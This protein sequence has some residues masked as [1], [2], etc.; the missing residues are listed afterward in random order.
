MP[1]PH[2][3]V[4][5]TMRAVDKNGFGQKVLRLEPHRDGRALARMQVAENLMGPEQTVGEQRLRTIQL[6]GRRARRECTCACRK[7]NPIYW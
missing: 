6:S 2:A 5:E 7:S 1:K 4:M 3:R